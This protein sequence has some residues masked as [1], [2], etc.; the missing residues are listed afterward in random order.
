MPIHLRFSLTIVAV[1]YG[2]L[3]RTRPGLLNLVVS[4]ED[5]FTRNGVLINSRDVVISEVSSERGVHC[6]M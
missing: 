1:C 3:E 5:D 2:I 4:L 6:I